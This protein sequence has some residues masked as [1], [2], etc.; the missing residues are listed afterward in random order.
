M[1]FTF[2]K[3]LF[4]NKLVAGAG[5]KNIFDVTDVDATAVTGG[6]HSGGGSGYGVG[7]GRTF[8]IK[9]TYNILRD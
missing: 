1:D 7:W 9:L 5:I 3:F 4:S 8:F 2:Q 6:V